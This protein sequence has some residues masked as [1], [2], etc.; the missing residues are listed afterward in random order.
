M[1]GWRRTIALGQAAVVA[2]AAVALTSCSDGGPKLHPVTGKVLFQDKPAEG[3]RVVLQPVGGGD[4]MPSGMTG[5]DGTFT[6]ATHP[7][8]E[9]APAGDYVVLLTWF[10]PNARELD[11]PKNKLPDRYADQAAGLI[12]A[13][14]KDGANQLDPIRLTK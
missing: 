7:Y 12:K 8:G 14:I 4:L 10:P 6:L 11:N 13:T 5:A 3:V 1:A 2:V 9:G